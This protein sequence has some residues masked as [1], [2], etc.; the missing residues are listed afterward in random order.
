MEK[1]E[2]S[3]SSCDADY[4]LQHDLDVPY[5]ITFCIFCGEEIDEEFLLECLT[6]YEESDYE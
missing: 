2:I 5:M 3:C 6:E 1:I 4:T